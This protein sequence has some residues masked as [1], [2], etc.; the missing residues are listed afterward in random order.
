MEGKPIYTRLTLEQPDRKLI[1]EYPFTDV[2]GDDMLEAV[3]MIMIG[4]GF[5][6]E[7]ILASLAR[8]LEEYG[9]DLYTVCRKVPGEE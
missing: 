7:S 2:D 6:P 5:R 3:K 4:M 1:F 8:Y 9:Q